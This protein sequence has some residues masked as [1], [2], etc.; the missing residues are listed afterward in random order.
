M[1]T[2]RT[3]ALLLTGT[4]ISHLPIARIFVYDT[5]FDTPHGPYMARR[6]EMHVNVME[7]AS[8]QHARCEEVVRAYDKHTVATRLFPLSLLNPE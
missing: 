3:N 5:H 2:L 4:P 7:S 6:Q 8:E 1:S